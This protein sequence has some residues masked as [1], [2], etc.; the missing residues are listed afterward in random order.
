MDCGR[1]LISLSVCRPY[2]MAQPPSNIAMM[3]PQPPPAVGGMQHA[4]V[5]GDPAP[6]TP[7][8]PQCQPEP[9][10]PKAPIPTE[11][12]ALHDVFDSLRTK[13]IA[14]ANH[15]VSKFLSFVSPQPNKHY[16]KILCSSKQ[17]E[18]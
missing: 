2:D 6:I 13:C 11:H 3:T 4:A 17:N 7:A 16:P 10:K 1:Y 14:A 5:M 8:A 15:P 12:Q 9:P 18:S